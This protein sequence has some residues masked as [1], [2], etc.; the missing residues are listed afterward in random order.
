MPLNVK[1]SSI[2]AYRPQKVSIVGDNNIFRVDKAR[3]TSCSWPIRSESANTC[4]MI[5]LNAGKN[6]NCLMHLAPEQQPLNSL[7]NGLER[8]IEKLKEKCDYKTAPVTAILIGG[9]AFDKKDSST[10]GSFDLYDTAANILDKLEIP[11]SMICGKYKGVANDNISIVGENAVIWNDSYKDIQLPKFV[12]QEEVAE[13][14]EEKY[15]VVELSDDV[16]VKIDI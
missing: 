13:L 12:S 3:F 5:G 2:S 8:C 11:F 4:V 1:L 6:K 15:Q 16:P 9:R 14:L 10:K 7:K